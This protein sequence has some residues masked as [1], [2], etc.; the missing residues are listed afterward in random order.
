MIIAAFIIIFLIALVLFRIF[1]NINS[2]QNIQN[3]KLSQND[4]L[5]MCQ[6]PT[7]N[8]NQCFQNKFIKCPNIN[9][10]YDQCTNNN[11]PNPDE[12]NCPCMN[13]TFEMCPSPF[14]ISE[15][16]Y[17]NLYKEMINKN[18]DIVVNKDFPRINMWKGD[19]NNDNFLIQRR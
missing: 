12:K 18:N 9:G 1:S 3:K 8:M 19:I 6:V 5:K 10:S 15:K 4:L 17:N 2:N 11:L 13:R 16:C 7:L 14:K